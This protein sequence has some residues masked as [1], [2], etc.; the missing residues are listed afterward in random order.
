MIESYAGMWTWGV[1]LWF[2][3]AAILT[4]GIIWLVSWLR[5]RSIGT[6]WYDWLI[7]AIGIALFLFTVQN[8]YGCWMEKVPQA[9]WMFVLVTGVPAL[10]LIGIAALQIWRR[11][12]KRIA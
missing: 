8:F 11:N 4:A 6:T 12:R 9:S 5:A 10:V 2:I 1:G 3:I 7:G